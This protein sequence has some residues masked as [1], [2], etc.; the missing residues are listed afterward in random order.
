M[1]VVDASVAV[2]WFI[3]EADSDK[4]TALLRSGQKLMAPEI[5]RV[6]VAA[7]LSR[8]FR[9]GQMPAP[10]VQTLLEDWREA[11]AQR[12]VS[13]TAILADFDMAVKLAMDLKHPLQ[14]CLYL[15]LAKRLNAP[16]LTA[17]KKFFEKIDPQQY[18]AQLL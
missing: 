3:L 2:K 4:A 10:T 18:H 11:L 6:E 16:F 1:I 15:A 7:A 8:L 9:T 12:A 14:D 17:D 13:L 5:I